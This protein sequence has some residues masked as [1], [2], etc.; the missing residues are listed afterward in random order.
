MSGQRQRTLVPRIRRGLL[1]AMV[2]L[3]VACATAATAHA[4]GLP[5]LGIDVGSTGLGTPDAGS[6]YVTLPGGAG[7]VVARVAQD[8]GQVLA[9]RALSARFTIPAVAYD[10]TASG[11]SADGAT[12][13]LISPRVNFPR[14]R[15]GLIV[16]DTHG[17]R[18]RRVV[19]LAGDFSFDAI[20][21]DGTRIYLIRYL[22][23][24]DPTRYQVR[25]YDVAAGGL[26]PDPIVDPAEP[27]EPM[28]GTPLSRS[29]SPDGRFAYTLYDRP[30]NVPF[31][32]VLDTAAGRARCVDLT[33][34]TG[35]PASAMRLKG[36]ADGTVLTVLDGEASVA[37]IETTNYRVTSPAAATRENV[38]RERHL[39][40]LAIA[41][42]LG[43]LL[44][45]G[46]ALVLVRRRRRAAPGRAEPGGAPSR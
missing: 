23:A 26:L 38:T 14:A 40:R 5:V 28:R 36:N 46:V 30:G 29:V 31:V 11:L 43:A 3:A 33:V 39:V 2:A 17:L 37:E 9:S 27:G 42:G 34:L 12:L 32:H 45:V 24:A 13:V 15:T 22:S 21:P 35:R 16:L 44:V 18:T 8:G 41:L 6:R 25:A 4:D 10:G 1:L 20:S 19:E 7:T